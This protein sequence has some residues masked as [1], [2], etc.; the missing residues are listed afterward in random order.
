[1]TTILIKRSTGTAAPS[2]LKT[3]ELAYSYGTGTQ[4]NLGDRLFFGKGDD[5]NGNATSVV[6]IGGEYFAN[7]LD[8]VAGTLT[9]SSAVIVDANSKIDRLLVDNITIGNTDDNTITTSSGD[10]VL[11]ATGNVQIASGTTLDANSNSITN[12]AAPTA[13]TDAANK[14][15]VDDQ[16]G[17]AVQLSINGDTGSED[18]INL[19]DSDL[20]IAGGTGIETAVTD[21][22]ITVTL[23]NTA[24]TAGS[25]GDSANIPIFTVNAQGQ[26]TSASTINLD[27]ISVDS[28]E[29]EAIFDTRLATKTTTDLAE[30]DNL[31]Y[32]TARADS[33]FDA[34]L[35]TKTTTD[36][37]EG[38]NL[39]YTTARADSDAKNAVSAGTGITYSAATGT[40]SADLTA[41]DHDQLLNYVANE[42]ID[43][44]SVTL[45][46]GNGLTGGGDITTS[47][48]FAI[49]AGNGITANAD[50][51]EVDM[52][53]FSTDDLSEGSNNL[54]YT[55]TRADSDARNA[56]TVTKAGGFGTLVYN[57]ADGTLVYTGIDSDQLANSAVTAG[58]GVTVVAGEVSIGQPVDSA[59]NVT[60]GTVTTSGNLTVG[61]NL[62]VD[63]NLTYV[64][65]Q[66]LQVTDNMIYLNAG[67]SSGSPTASIDLGWAGNYNEGGSY[68]HAGMFRDATDQTFKVYQ[69]YTPEPDEAAQIDTAHASF[70]LANFE[71]GVITATEFNGVY[72]GFDSDFAAKST[73]DLSEGSNLYYTT[74]RVDSDLADILVAGEGIDITN[75][76]GTYTIS[77]EDASDTN[78]GIAS[79]DATN[80]TVTGGNVVANDITFTAGDASTA[81]VTNGESLTINGDGVITTA[82][83]GS[84]L[85]V[86]VQDATVAQKGVAQFDSD[87]FDVT[88]G[89]VTVA[90]VDGGTY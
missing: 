5:G 51:I 40:I 26:I 70:Q 75:G 82:I 85:T 48:T 22:T 15:Y 68:A 30:G 44:T 4:A 36:L 39:Y 14:G 73:D 27:N 52:S 69:G 47:R 28:A 9:A 24:V 38:D 54:Y 42:H 12:V 79:F 21:N 83:S 11:G 10:L 50:D 18:G 86:S 89:L 60:F 77:G 71:A 62:Q 35:T 67:E 46:A 76:V 33:A 53:V 72:A 19:A 63:G 13:A 2:N 56:L 43:H 31:Y 81:D 49:G 74:T 64:D 59:A 34:R 90:T 16:I 8:H 20:T 32:T 1:M 25:Y 84:T 3:G 7:M 45:T 87:Q 61:G 55:D 88:A 58:T 37:A 23:S 80:F 6:V 41:I 29:V 57:P 66:T 17:G 65:T 78:K